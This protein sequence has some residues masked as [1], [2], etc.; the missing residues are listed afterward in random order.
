[1]EILL[2]KVSF[3]PGKYISFITEQEWSQTNNSDDFQKI[4]Q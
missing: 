2:K 4:P 1:M 3:C